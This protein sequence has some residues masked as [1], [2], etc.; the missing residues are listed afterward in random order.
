MTFNE[1]S[2]LPPPDAS[3]QAIF[4]QGH[5]VGDWAKKLFPEGVEVPF[6]KGFKFTLDLTQELVKERK[7]IFEASFSAEGLYGRADVP[8]P[9]R[10]ARNGISS[11]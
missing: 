1:P 7:T 5:E 10:G 3:T 11:R 2:A 9:C 4:D 8:A 6:E